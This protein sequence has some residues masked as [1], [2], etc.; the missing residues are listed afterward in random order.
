LTI[1][2]KQF[3]TLVYVECYVL[4]SKLFGLRTFGFHIYFV[5]QQAGESLLFFSLHRVKVT[6]GSKG[7]KESIVNWRC[8][9]Y[10]CPHR[11]GLT[12]L[13][14]LLPGHVGG[15]FSAECPAGNTLLNRYG[16]NPGGTSDAGCT[17]LSSPRSRWSIHFPTP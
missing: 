2:L 15:P 1:Q 12:L 17:F 7:F 13:S 5:G 14:M 11:G 16:W 10:C 4:Y 3:G 9:I 8:K 6:T